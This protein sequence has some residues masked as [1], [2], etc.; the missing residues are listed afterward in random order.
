MAGRLGRAGSIPASYSGDP[1]F[2][3]GPKKGCHVSG[4]RD[5]PQTLQVNAGTVRSLL[6]HPYQFIIH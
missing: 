4:H 1:H 3:I 6:P 2:K 5:F